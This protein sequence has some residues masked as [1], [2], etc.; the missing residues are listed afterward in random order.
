[1][2][3]TSLMQLAYIVAQESKCIS[4]KVGALISKDERII[5]TGY[6][7]TPAGQ[8]N[9]CDVAH[10]EG[11]TDENGHMHED[12]GNKHTEWSQKNEIH[13]ELNAILYAAKRGI[14][15][16]GATMYVTVSP[17]ADCAKAIAQSGIKQLVYCVDYPRNP[18]NWTNILVESNI[19]VR[20]L[21]K[22]HLNLLNWE[23]INDKLPRT[24]KN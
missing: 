3:S 14:S 5:S 8:A 1:M 7:G 17:C 21:D 6:N 23:H 16:E 10:D 18:D 15:I 4:W 13:A 22:R 20:K 9:C 24:V 19:I 12:C 11:W 2:K